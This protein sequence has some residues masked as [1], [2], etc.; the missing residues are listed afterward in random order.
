MNKLKTENKYFEHLDGTRFF[1]FLLVFLVHCFVSVDSNIGDS[2]L[3][4]AVEDFFKVG[5]LGVDFFFVLSGFLISW[6]ILNEKEKTKKFRFGHFFARRALRIWPLYFLI[7]LLGYTFYY[8]S[9]SARMEISGLPPFYN[10][11]LFIVNFYSIYE[12]IDY[13]FFLTFLWSVSIE[14]QFYIGYSV[15]AKVFFRLNLLLVAIVLILVSLVYRFYN[16]ENGQELYFHTFSVLGNFGVGILVAYLAQRKN[17]IYNW[18]E[19]RSNLFSSVIYFVLFGSLIYYNE[20]NEIEGFRIFSRLYF[21]CLF[22]YIIFEQCFSKD[23]FLSFGKSRII[24][25]L[26]KI[27]F[28]LYCY[29]GVVITILIKTLEKFEF[30]ETLWH[31][32]LISPIIIL[33]VSIGLSALSYKYFEGFFLKLKK[34]YSA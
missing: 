22:G 16:I 19:S 34:K 20:L 23:R 8:Y 5:F 12:G 33:T 10:F 2:E 21:S 15:L 14:E 32:F 6:V 18:L 1:A 3:Y 26:G 13:L 31:V 27:S 17:Q 24:K 4:K 9:V 7:V 25:Y 11:A 30:E 29:H 28:G